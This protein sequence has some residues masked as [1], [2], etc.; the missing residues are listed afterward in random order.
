MFIVKPDL[1]ETHVEPW[2]DCTHHAS[3]LLYWTGSMLWNCDYFIH[4]SL[5]TCNHFIIF[6]VPTYLPQTHDGIELSLILLMVCW[7]LCQLGQVQGAD[8]VVWRFPLW[9]SILMEIVTLFCSV[10]TLFD[11]VFQIWDH[12]SQ[13]QLQSTTVYILTTDLIRSKH[14]NGRKQHYY[15]GFYPMKMWKN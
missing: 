14:F 8:C 15:I 13:R 10:V 9:R 4:V 7:A 12:V 1:H 3:H 6:D 5:E 2:C 11:I